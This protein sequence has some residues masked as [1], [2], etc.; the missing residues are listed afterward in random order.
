MNYKYYNA[1][2]HNNFIEDCVIRSISL[3]EKK[4]WDYTYS[5]LS[6]LARKKGLLFSDAS[7]VENYLDSKYKRI[8]TPNMKVGDFAKKHKKG[9]Y[10]ITMPNHITCSYHGTI[11]DS[12][13]CTNRPLRNAWY[14]GI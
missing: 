11:V 6:N 8:K 14:V 7:F 10:L 4:S 5:K 3:A 1:N 13:D 12:F 9:I 2:S